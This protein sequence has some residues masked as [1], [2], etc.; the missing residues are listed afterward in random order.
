MSA[1]PLVGAGFVLV[2]V[3]LRRTSAYAAAWA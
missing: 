3:V 2:A 1:K